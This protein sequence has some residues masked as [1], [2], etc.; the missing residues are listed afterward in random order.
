MLLGILLAVAS[1]P[2]SQSGKNTES[3]GISGSEVQE[4]QS[5]MEKKLQNLLESVEGVGK[6]K[7][8]LMTGGD[9]SVFE[10]DT[11]KIT[12]VLIAAEGGDDPGVVQNIQ[13]AVMALY[14]VEAHKIKIMKMK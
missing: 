3:T 11:Q 10:S 6:V 14:Q 13:Q 1:L 5:E 4:N 7:V 2:V 9:K 12:G 8:I